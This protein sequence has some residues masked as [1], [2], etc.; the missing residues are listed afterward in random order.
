L[1]EREFGREPERWR[2]PVPVLYSGFPAALELGLFLVLVPVK[3][4]F[5]VRT[6]RGKGW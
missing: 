3:W 5:E 1:A 4:V 6:L 2:G